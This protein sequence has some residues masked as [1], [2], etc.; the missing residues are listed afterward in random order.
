MAMELVFT[1]TGLFIAQWTN[2][3]LGTNNGP[4]AFLVPILLQIVFPC[5]T[6]AFLL[7]GLPESP[8]YATPMLGV[9]FSLQEQT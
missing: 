2:F 7:S 6:I 3:G 8:R 9:S 1:A 4:A 5:I